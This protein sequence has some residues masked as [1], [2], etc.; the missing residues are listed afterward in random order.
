MKKIILAVCFAAS[1]SYAQIPTW[2]S[3]HSHPKYPVTEYIIGV[4]TGGGETG[5]ESAK[6]AALADIAAQLRVQVQSEMRTVT[7]SFSVNDDE[8]IYSDFKR[9]SRTAVNDEITGAD[10]IETVVDA[11]SSTTYALVV[12]NREKY[13]GALRSE[14]ESGWTQAR[15]LRAAAAAFASQGKLTEA[16]Q[17]IDQIK[18]V[19][20]P[21]FTKQVL[22]NAAAK[23]PFVFP[24]AFNPAALQA[25]IRTMLSNVRLTK[26]SGDGQQGTIGEKFPSPLAVA[27][28]V[29]GVPCAGVPVVFV[30]DDKTVLGEAV[31][32]ANGT[33]NI[34]TIVRNGKGIKAK[35]A[36][37]GLGREFE[38][39]LNASSVVFTWTTRAS[40]K[41]FSLTVTAKNKKAADAVQSKLTS[42]VSQIGYKVV[43]M[44]N[45]ALTAEISAGVPNTIQGMAGTLYNLT[46]EVTVSLKE[47]K[48]NSIL[49][50]VKFSAKGVGKSED[51]ALEK[52]AGALKISENDLA[53][54][55]QK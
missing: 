22:H 26:K 34:S 17:S 54:L 9:Q 45:Y 28:T 33:A 36:L 14:L 38:Q 52:A 39:N 47:N 11:Q 6:K 19:L 48:S 20:A 15:D 37:K 46:M 3:T 40:D 10:V 1:M 23:S 42:A 24:A 44:S 21:L 4:G 51:E 5:A 41:A 53:D 35:L 13:S 49:G 2:F 27:V 16:L 25:D 18:A 12:L 30:L 32:D 7:E 55:L 31:T 50:A 8:Q 29:G 43:T